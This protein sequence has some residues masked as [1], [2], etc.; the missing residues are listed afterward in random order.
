M[1]AKNTQVIEGAIQGGKFCP[2]GGRRT[3]SMLEAGMLLGM[4]PHEICRAISSGDLEVFRVG[5][6]WRFHPSALNEFHAQDH[7]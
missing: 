2:A 4:S 7:S 3:F 6:D 5:Y 1:E